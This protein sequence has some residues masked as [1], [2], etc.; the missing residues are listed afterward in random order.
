MTT[1]NLETAADLVA[2]LGTPPNDIAEGWLDDARTHIASYSATTFDASDPVWE[3]L[4]IDESGRLYLPNDS[5]S[6]DTP[7][8]EISDTDAAEQDAIKPALA[9]IPDF[10]TE[11]EER[12]QGSD[13]RTDHDKPRNLKRFAVPGIAIGI[14]A[15][16]IAAYTLRGSFDDQSPQST[17]MSTPDKST[18]AASSADSASNVF[19]TRSARKPST[20]PFDQDVSAETLETVMDTAEMPNTDVIPR[21]ANVDTSLLGVSLDSFLPPSISNV[22]DDDTPSTAGSNDSIEGSP[23]PTP[24]ILDGSNTPTSEIASVDIAADDSEL[25]DDEML[26]DAEE[27]QTQSISSSEPQTTSVSL[28][29][30]PTKSRTELPPTVLIFAN[31][32]RLENLQ[33]EFPDDSPLRL[34]TDS[35]DNEWKITEASDGTPLARIEMQPGDDETESGLT[36]RWLA[37]AADSRSSDAIINGRLRTDAGDIIHLRSQLDAAPIPLNLQRRDE[38]L[39]WNLSGPIVA[40]STRLSVSVDVPEDVAIEW[41]EEIDGGSPRSTRGIAILTLK[42]SP[43]ASALVVRMDIRTSGSLSMRVRYGGR[44]GPTMPWQWTDAKTIRSTLDAVTAQLQAA[45][46]QLLML[47]TAISRAEKL[48]ARRQEV[49]LEMQRDRIE[50]AVRGGTAMA[51][52]LAELDQLVALLDADAKITSELNVHWPDGSIQTLL[53]LR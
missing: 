1:E 6:P 49:S 36:F 15:V 16:A 22:V 51:K 53:S 41:I 52:R 30:A 8:S 37:E 17:A 40:K 29:K 31:E 9:T 18:D 23:S 28:P 24:E 47:D 7:K 39:K 35:S 20:R 44:L 25:S 13:V 34:Q 10:E 19:D 3:Q 48:R 26:D 14:I 2:R 45:D 46:E 27:Q 38:K 4:F 42:D 5:A 12:S 11:P 43:D 32:S 21:D 50:E 33:F